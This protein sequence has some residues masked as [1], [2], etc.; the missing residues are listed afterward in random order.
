MPGVTPTAHPAAPAPARAGSVSE[1]PGVK[2]EELGAQPRAWHIRWLRDAV[3][4]A[5]SQ[6]LGYLCTCPPQPGHLHLSVKL[7]TV[8]PSVPSDEHTGTP[9]GTI[10]LSAAT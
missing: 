6:P 3:P 10:R 5:V 4:S 7:Q 9:M 8:P 2:L 1:S